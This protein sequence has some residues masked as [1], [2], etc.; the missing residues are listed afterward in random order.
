[1]LE[2]ETFKELT[3]KKANMADAERIGK[4]RIMLK[5]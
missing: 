1:M 2:Q 4:R 5:R 3:G